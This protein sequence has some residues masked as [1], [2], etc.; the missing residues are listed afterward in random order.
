MFVLDNLFKGIKEKRTPAVK[1]IGNVDIG[2]VIVFHHSPVKTP[3]K[4]SLDDVRK[5]K[6][7]SP[8]KPDLLTSRGV[9]IELNK[10]IGA[11]VQIKVALAF[12]DTVIDETKND[13]KKSKMS[14]FVEDDSSGLRMGLMGKRVIRLDQT[15]DFALS[16]ESSPIIRGTL[17]DQKFDELLKARVYAKEHEEEMKKPS[18][19]GNGFISQKREKI[20]AFSR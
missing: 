2:D 12:G 7:R 19:R 17:S 18:I 13:P 8:N 1:N 9:V 3:E 11:K 5:G 20:Q 4:Y 16:R 14:V 6:V 15:I 10:T